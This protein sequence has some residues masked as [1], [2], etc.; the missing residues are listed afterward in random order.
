MTKY[1]TFNFIIPRETRATN[2][3]SHR[4]RCKTTVY[5]S[6][7]AVI[8]VTHSVTELYI[9][10][11]ARMTDADGMVAAM[12]TRSTR[13]TRWSLSAGHLTQSLP[14]RFSAQVLLQ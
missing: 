7:E 13:T 9:G 3:S 11:A 14:Y 10:K 6:L 4:A 8:R 12:T 2:S 1:L 5:D